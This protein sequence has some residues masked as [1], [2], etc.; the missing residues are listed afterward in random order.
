MP[1]HI[2]QGVKDYESFEPWAEA[3]PTVKGL[4]KLI[5]QA[6]H[7]QE[8]KPGQQITL[9]KNKNYWKSSGKK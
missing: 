2:W 4:T 1:K 5:A 6:L 9:V 8:Y 7:L 3:H